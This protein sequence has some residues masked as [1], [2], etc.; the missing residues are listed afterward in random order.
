LSYS[1]RASTNFLLKDSVNGPGAI[2]AARCESKS[3]MVLTR[4]GKNAQII[5]HYR[6]KAMLQIHMTRDSP[7]SHAESSFS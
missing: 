5:T 3:V 4:E 1:A 7:I 2:L 6:T